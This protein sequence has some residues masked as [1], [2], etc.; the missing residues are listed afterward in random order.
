M[1]V[2]PFNALAR[3]QIAHHTCKQCRV[4]AAAGSPHGS[5]LCPTSFTIVYAG[6]SACLARDA[7]MRTA[8]EEGG[9]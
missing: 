9:S 5:W 8:S 2:S 1:S 4:F 7:Q 3:R 6:K